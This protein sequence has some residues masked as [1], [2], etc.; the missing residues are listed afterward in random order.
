MMG[1]M[2]PINFI[3]LGAL[4]PERVKNA[5]SL[6]NLT[7]NLGGAVGLALLTTVLNVR[8]D[9]HLV[10]LRD[11]ATDA[12]GPVT[13]FLA[14]L[15]QRFSD[16]G[17]DAPQ[18]ALKTLA[19]IVHRQGVVLAFSDVFLVLTLLFVALVPT[20]ALLNRPAVGRAPPKDAH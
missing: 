3:T 13:E 7:R 1:C 11:N 19:Q 16:F 10:R 14:Q 15:T 12:H 9:L 17:S 20:V 5:A 4:P 6:Y 18:M 2:V 8:T